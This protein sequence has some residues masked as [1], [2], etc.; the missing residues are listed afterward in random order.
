MQPLK[1]L[2]LGKGDPWAADITGWAAAAPRVGS[3]PQD[4]GSMDI[5][6]Q[7]YYIH[8]FAATWL[9]WTEEK[10]NK[11]KKTM[12]FFYWP[13]QGATGRPEILGPPP[14]GPVKRQQVSK[15][16]WIE[17]KRTLIVH[18]G[19]VAWLR[20]EHDPWTIRLASTE[21]GVFAR[22]R[23]LCD[24]AGRSCEHNLPR[25]PP[26][27]KVGTGLLVAPPG[28]GPFRAIAPSATCPLGHRL[29]DAGKSPYG[30]RKRGFLGAWTCD[31]TLTEPG[32]ACPEFSHPD[33][34]GSFYGGEQRMYA[35]AL[36]CAWG[37][38]AHCA[39]RA[40]RAGNAATG[41]TV[42]QCP[43]GH[44]V[45][46]VETAAEVRCYTC[47]GRVP[48]GRRARGCLQCIK[49]DPSKTPFC[50]CAACFYPAAIEPAELTDLDVIRA[51]N[52]K[53]AQELGRTLVDDDAHTR[54]PDMRKKL[55]H[56][57]TWPEKAWAE[58]P[59][60]ITAYDPLPSAGI[61]R[62]R[63]GDGRLIGF[64]IYKSSHE[65]SRGSRPAAVSYSSSP[66]QSK[67]PLPL[68]VLSVWVDPA[69]RMRGIAR[70]LVEAVVDIA[71]RRRCAKVLLEVF[72]TNEKAI[73]VYDGM[74]FETT[75]TKKERLLRDAAGWENQPQWVT[76]QREL[77]WDDVSQ[78]WGQESKFSSSPIV[79]MKSSGGKRRRV[80]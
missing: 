22:L 34:S 54:Y 36:G 63:S 17:S 31:G 74:G 9:F 50:I 8:H 12:R 47:R 23:A 11:R 1:P 6:D 18:C 3:A 4:T 57:L 59:E 5:Y 7:Q 77:T 71:H 55:Q 60:R 19:D 13:P 69:L 38:C 49:A 10:T 26:K 44:A 66:K 70:R 29:V 43:Y 75:S 61:L 21:G 42:T 64:I 14:K 79:G 62:A 51:A 48:R 78:E 41:L 39:Q 56:I 25:A 37:V 68:W 46:Y 27:R 58:W 40:E 35:C 15:L 52:D 28:D 53:K 45:E 24:R 30:T 80:I 76:L 32:C 2:V 72:D 65:T 33:G 20:R 16:E 73:S 67:G